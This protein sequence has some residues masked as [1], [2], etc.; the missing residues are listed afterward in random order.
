MASWEFMSLLGE[1]AGTQA[2]MFPVA[3]SKQRSKALN[4]IFM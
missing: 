4:Q 1:E 3:R 2:P